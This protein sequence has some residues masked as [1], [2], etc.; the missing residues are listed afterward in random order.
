MWKFG[1][2]SSVILGV[3]AYGMPSVAGACGGTF[4]DAAQPTEMPVDQTGETILFALDNGYVEAHIQIEYDGGDADQFAWLVPVPEVPEVEVGSWRLVQA[5]L[6]GTRPVYGYEDAQQCDDD[7][8]GLTAGG[9][10]FL[11]SPDGGGSTGEPTVVAEDVVGAFQY[12]VLEG[13]SAQTVTDW[14]QA[15][16]YAVEDEAPAILDDYI[17]EGHVFVAFRLR[18]GQAVEDIHPVVIRYPGVEPCIPIRLTRVAAKEDMDIRALFLG[19]ARVVATNYREVRLNRTRLNWAGL[20]SNYREL[21]TMAV[22]AP[23]ADGRAFVTEYAGS[24][25]VIDGTGLDTS[26]FDPAAL[27]GVSVVEVVDVLESQGLLT[28]DDQGCAW[29]HELAPSLLHEFLPVPEGLDEAE[30]YGCVSCYAPLID[31]AAWNE[32]AFIDAYE[33]RIVAPLAHGA[34]LLKIWPYV[35]R[36]YTTI[37]P[38]EMLSDPMFEEN[39]AL[40]DV[41]SRHGAQRNL[42]CCGTSMRLPGGRLVWLDD[43]SWP[44]WEAGMPWAEEVIEHAPGGRAP[45]VLAD[46]SAVIDAA[47]DAW[48]DA[49]ACDDTGTGTGPGDTTG[50]DTGLGSDTGE[51]L[52]T[53]GTD[54]GPGAG[55]DEAGTGCGCRAQPTGSGWGLM[56]LGL[57]LGW[58]RR[59]SS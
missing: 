26:S 4:C 43:G 5:A 48:N 41:A 20:G 40:P 17:A 25:T 7:D 29:F 46:H 21:V 30:F 11:Q 47:L 42:E 34:D 32:G 56:L 22:D 49:A 9:G 38:H 51:G 12:A 52:G 24:S 28:C 19:D 31:M 13:G 33:E 27:V 1:L 6:D 55:G 57:G 16:D 39:P 59:R 35:T 2:G 23:G 3:V 8:G 50:L 53:G 45:V 14:L 44:T 10:G 58:T 36:L 54:T 15:N 37:S 18:H